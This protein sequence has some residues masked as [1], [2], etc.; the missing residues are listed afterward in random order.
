M[1]EPELP[2]PLDDPEGE[3]E[4]YATLEREDEYDDAVGDDCEPAASSTDV[5]VAPAKKSTPM[6]R[7]LALR[8][9]FSD[10]VATGSRREI[11]KRRPPHELPASVQGEPDSPAPAQPARD[12]ARRQRRK[13]TLRSTWREI[14]VEL[15]LSDAPR[16]LFS[17][18]ATVAW[19]T[20]DASSVC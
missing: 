5:V 13:R 18:S 3:D 12:R 17:H 2:K 15:A 6:E 1:L 16:F 19:I 7:C 9:I 20:A 11:S 14:R 8:S 10:D 4:V